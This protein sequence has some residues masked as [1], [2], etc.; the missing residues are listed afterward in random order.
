[1]LSRKQTFIPGL[2]SLDVPSSF[3]CGCKA[4]AILLMLAAIT[5]TAKSRVHK[6]AP[7]RIKGSYVIAAICKEGIIVASDSRGTL[8]NGHGRRIAYYD[9]NQKIFPVGNK[10]IADTGYASLNDPTISFLAALMSQFGSAPASHVDVEQLPHAYFKYANTVLPEAGAESAKIQ[11]LIF[12]GFT[13]NKPVMCIY[14]GESGRGTKCRYSGYLAS[15]NQQIPGLSHV[16]TLS[17]REAAN[18]MRQTINAYAAAVQPGSVG[19]P[20]VIR[21]I[22][23]SAAS[24]WLEMPPRWPKWRVFTDLAEDYK[25][26]RVMFNLMPGIGKGELDSLVEDG[27]TWARLGAEPNQPTVANPAPIIGSYPDQ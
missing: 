21:T 1:M 17:F 7:I 3:H 22:Q 12:A 13:S 10:V 6:S 8:K 19:G 15:P 18:V 26:G 4:L 27:A 25:S 20:V 5:A 23:S 11:T 9:V 24:A 14:D 2:S 16:E